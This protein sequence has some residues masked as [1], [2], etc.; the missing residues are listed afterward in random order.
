MGGSEPRTGSAPRTGPC[1]AVPQR[2]TRGWRC[3]CPRSTSSSSAYCS[4]CTG[5]AS[6]TEARR[7]CA[8]TCMYDG[9]ERR[10]AHAT[11][12]AP[13]GR[14][15][16]PLCSWAC[17][18][19]QIHVSSIHVP[20]AILCVPSGTALSF[21]MIAVTRRST[22]THSLAFFR[23]SPADLDRRATK[24]SHSKGLTYTACALILRICFCS[25]WFCFCVLYSALNRG[26]DHALKPLLE[27][28]GTVSTQR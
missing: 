19:C 22:Y 13:L 4:A 9:R 10:L 1:S 3:C 12:R 25:F 11:A 7:I 14:P 27:R 15:E 2:S 26:G 6:W 16:S 21:R 23:S 18:L 24:P 5:A 20:F 17:R 8:H 28:Q